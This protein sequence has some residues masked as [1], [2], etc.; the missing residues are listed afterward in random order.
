MTL[1]QLLALDAIVATGTF[2]G[3]AE[4]LNKAQ[5]AVS[6][7]MKALEDFLGV[8]L[9]HRRSRQVTLTTE[10]RAYLTPIRDALEQI[11]VATE[12]IRCTEAAGSITLSVA[13]SFATGWLMPRLAQ[14]QLA[15]PDIEV[16]LISAIELADF[17]VADV[18]AAIRTG[19]GSWP[20]LR[21]HRL[22]AE[23]LVPV[24]SADFVRL[25]SPEDLRHATLLHEIPRLG[26]WRSW[27]AAVGI[28]D[29][30]AERGPKFQGASMAVEAAVA[31]L[32]VAIANRALVEAHVREG[33]LVIPFAIELPSESAYY[34]VYPEE[35]TR[36]A[37][38]IAFK[39]WVLGMLKN[40][41]A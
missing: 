39:D 32:G 7:Q 30:D 34:L 33:R 18:D 41:Q 27:L 9:F 28:V 40:P 15:Y 19:R 8:K 20:G 37:K 22:I 31:G 4:R 21:S 23:E 25:R 29:V 13:P 35:R 14:F 11:R 36:N 17:S 10:G 2:R 12:Q 24:C 16:R 38:I 1:D 26:L 5:S 3:A 6:H